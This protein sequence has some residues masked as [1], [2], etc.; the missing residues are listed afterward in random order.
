VGES[1]LFLKYVK[2]LFFS[3]VH[4]LIVSLFY[5]KKKLFLFVFGATA[6]SG[7]GS[8]HSRGF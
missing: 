7:Q 6:P 8:P 3:P 4:C 2:E 1:P 5:E